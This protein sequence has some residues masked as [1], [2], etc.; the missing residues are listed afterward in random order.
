MLKRDLHG[1]L[2]DDVA[3]SLTTEEKDWL[4]SWNR[5]DEIPGE[6]S[7]DGSQ[8]YNKMKKDDLLGEIEARNAGRPEEDH[9]VPD[10]DKKDN[11][12]AALEADDEDQAS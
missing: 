1:P 11:L 5:A 10:G 2:E 12:V 8:D 6:D 3:D 7:G 4:R 9:I